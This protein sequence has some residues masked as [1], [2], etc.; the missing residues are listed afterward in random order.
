VLPGAARRPKD[1]ARILRGD[2]DTIVAKTLKKNPE[3]RYPSVT[4][5]AGDI[6][7]YLNHEPISARPTRSLTGRPNSRGGG[8]RAAW[9]RRQR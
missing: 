2:L 8:I 1:C 6:R 9:L 7:R 5:F 4:A 3:E